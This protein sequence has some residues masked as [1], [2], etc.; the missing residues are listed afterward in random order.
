[1]AKKKGGDRLDQ[2]PPELRGPAQN[3]YNGHQT[4]RVRGFPGNTYG[5]AS[6]CRTMGDE[7]RRAVAATYGYSVK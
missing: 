6:P 5:K 2:Y 7:E 4:Q 3:R 1:M